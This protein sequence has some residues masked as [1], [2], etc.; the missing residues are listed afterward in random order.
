MGIN[1][2]QN[3]YNISCDYCQTNKTKDYYEYDVMMSVETTK[4]WRKNY[5]TG[6]CTCPDCVK[7]QNEKI[8]A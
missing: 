2:G 7:R 3:Y 6:N 5:I 8:K 1:V 4:G